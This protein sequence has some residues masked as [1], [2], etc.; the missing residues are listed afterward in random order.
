MRFGCSLIAALG[1][2]AS[3]ARADNCDPAAKPDLKSKDSAKRVPAIKACLLQVATPISSDA[4]LA[5][6][7]GPV[8]KLITYGSKEKMASMKAKTGAQLEEFQVALVQRREERTALA[9]FS[10]VPKDQLDALIA[11]ARKLAQD[12]HDYADLAAAW[13]K[14][15]KPKAPESTKYMAAAFSKLYPR[16]LDHLKGDFNDPG[17]KKTKLQQ[18]GEAIGDKLDIG[19]DSTAGMGIYFA[20]DGV[21]SAEHVRGEAAGLVCPVAGMKIVNLDKKPVY[22]ALMKA[23]ILIPQD[24]RTEELVFISSPSKKNLWNMPS[25]TEKAAGGML[26]AF[27]PAKRSVN[28]DDFPYIA[29]KFGINYTKCWDVSVRD[30]TQCKHFKRLIDAD[31]GNGDIKALLEK[32]PKFYPSLT[33]TWA[34]CA[35]ADKTLCAGL[36]KGTGALQAVVAG[37]KQENLKTV[38]AACGCKTSLGKTTCK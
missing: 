32:D 13:I 4:D 31:F 16:F 34:S 17:V 1:L 5:R 28:K 14:A 35:K 29:D 9:N 23:K 3:A 8:N 38:L 24:L 22:E 10:R 19:F 26:V 12:N 11:D 30:F 18:D 21:D 7:V 37:A 2:A 27:R 25:D 33:G 6:F 36:P 15:G 20:L